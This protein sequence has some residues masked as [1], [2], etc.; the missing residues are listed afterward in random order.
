M[1]LKFKLIHGVEKNQE[2]IR[3]NKIQINLKFISGSK[4]RIILERFI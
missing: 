2:K 4:G 3:I 1:V